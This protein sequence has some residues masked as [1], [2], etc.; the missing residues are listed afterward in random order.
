MSVLRGPALLEIRGGLVDH[1]AWCAR[2]ALGGSGQD[3]YE[4]LVKAG[5]TV[6][7]TT[8]GTNAS[9]MTGFASSPNAP[10]AEP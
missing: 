9:R 10:L 6:C 7:S 2:V 8:I 4:R 1:L 3:R 5:L